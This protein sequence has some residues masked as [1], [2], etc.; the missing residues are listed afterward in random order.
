MGIVNL[1]ES[2]NDDS[3]DN[4]GYLIHLK[5][6]KQFNKEANMFSARTS[7]HK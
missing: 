7:A 2:Y 6:S 1:I 3:D 5:R 4:D